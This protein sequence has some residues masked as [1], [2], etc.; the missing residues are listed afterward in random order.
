MN[1]EVASSFGGTGM[2]IYQA[3]DSYGV[4]AKKIFLNAG[5]NLGQLTD[6]GVRISTKVMLNL[7]TR[8][9]EE[10]QD[11]C[12]GLTY[13]EY[14]H[15]TSF[16]ALGLALLSS[17]TLRAFCER[18]HRYFSFFSTGEM[19]KFE[20]TDN[21]ACLIIK[22]AAEIQDTGVCRIFIDGTMAFIIK[23]IRLMYQPDFSPDKVELVCSASPEE[24]LR[25]RNYYRS[26]IRFSSPSNVLWLDPSELDKPLPAANTQIALENDQVV[27]N[28]LENMNQADLVSQ[29]RTKIIELLPS[30]N[31]SREKVAEILKMSTRTLYGKL[32]HAGTN[33]Q[34]ILESTRKELGKQYINQSAMTVNE[35]GY[36]LGFSN[37]SCFS[38]AF[39]NWTGLSP[40]AYRMNQV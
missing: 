27:Q 2:V 1:K 10:T 29:V 38:R 20:E 18:L 15:P 8:V 32:D 17:S 13:A 23:L 35:I 31:C 39:K 34:E 30:G 33:Y 22:P 14:V 37:S 16:H 3:L 19:V 6:P 9:K 21:Q 28:Y 24:Q 11:L 25:Y 26:A 12:F 4:D 7:L 40:K 36:L 5:L